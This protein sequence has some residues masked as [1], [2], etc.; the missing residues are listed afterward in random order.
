MLV[1]HLSKIFITSFCFMFKAISIEHA[2]EKKCKPFNSMSLKKNQV[3]WLT[4]ASS[5]IPNHRQYQ[6]LPNSQPLLWV[7]ELTFIQQETSSPKWS[8]AAKYPWQHPKE[9]M[10]LFKQEVT[11]RLVVA[12]K[13]PKNHFVKNSWNNSL[14]QA[15]NDG[16]KRNLL[17]A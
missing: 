8:I 16:K 11:R 15:P 17:L 6:V 4:Q 7:H 13:N 14:I 9:D 10:S 12:N 2:K 5:I 3:I 1:P